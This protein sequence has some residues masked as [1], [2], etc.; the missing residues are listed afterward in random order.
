MTAFHVDWQSFGPNREDWPDS[1]FRFR[2][3]RN[4][5]PRPKAKPRTM[6]HEDRIVLDHHS[7]PVKDF[8]QVRE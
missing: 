6:Y 5:H 4:V 1:L 3:E 7:C 2:E 8:P